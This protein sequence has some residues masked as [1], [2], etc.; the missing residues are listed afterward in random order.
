MRVCGF[1]IIW[2]CIT[3][4]FYAFVPH[5]FVFYPLPMRYLACVS[6]SIWFSI[7]CRTQKVPVS[8]VFPA[9]TRWML[10]LAEPGRNPFPQF[11]RCEGACRKLKKTLYK[12]SIAFLGFSY[13]LTCSMVL[14]CFVCS[15]YQKVHKYSWNH[16]H[17][18]KLFPRSPC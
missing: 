4:K 17:T 8:I 11:F 13:V 14:K 9:D 15:K 16:P 12:I 7:S 2:I 1:M 6:Y 3:F 5:H 18:L 10:L